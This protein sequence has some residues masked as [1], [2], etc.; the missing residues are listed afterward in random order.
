MLRGFLTFITTFIVIGLLIILI[1][2]L[3]GHLACFISL[4]NSINGL[5]FVGIGVSIH[6]K[7]FLIKC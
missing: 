5:I 1:G 3:S 4:R 7:K 2:D 6:G